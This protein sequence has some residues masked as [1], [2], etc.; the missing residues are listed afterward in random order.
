[1]NMVVPDLNSQYVY[2][3]ANFSYAGSFS[4]VSS[5]SKASQSSS[6]KTTSSD[7]LKNIRGS[8]N[9]PNEQGLYSVKNALIKYENSSKESDSN[10]K[11][12]MP[13]VIYSAG[14]YILRQLSLNSQL[15]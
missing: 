12:L 3:N 13:I 14:F 5:G 2:T 15:S 8:G 9:N 1:M 4:T 10:G 7:V 11:D 6:C